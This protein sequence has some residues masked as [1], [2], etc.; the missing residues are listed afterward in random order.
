MVVKKIHHTYAIHNLNGAKLLGHR[1]I[2]IKSVF[3][4]CSALLSLTLFC[5]AFFTG[6][7]HFDSCTFERGVKNNS[8]LKS[9]SNRLSYHRISKRLSEMCL[10]SKAEKKTRYFFAIAAFLLLLSLLPLLFF[11]MFEISLEIWMLQSVLPLNQQKNKI[12]PF[13]F[14][15]GN[16]KPEEIS[17]EVNRYKSIF[18]HL[19]FA[20]KLVTCFA[21]FYRHESNS[22]D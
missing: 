7:L 17:V 5:L 10:S 11:Y 4:S 1:H 12:V 2:G 16:K 9:T 19:F 13:R 20:Y 3:F 8:L 6:A 15:I 14:C 21:L 22:D 18:S